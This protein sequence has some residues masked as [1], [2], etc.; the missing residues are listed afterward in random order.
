MCGLNSQSEAKSLMLLR[1][2]PARRPSSYPTLDMAPEVMFC[3]AHIIFILWFTFSPRAIILQPLGL[4]LKQNSGLRLPSFEAG[5][6][7]LGKISQYS[8]ASAP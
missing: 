3:L 7:P 1:P 8:S 6:H 5:F 4:W 2:E